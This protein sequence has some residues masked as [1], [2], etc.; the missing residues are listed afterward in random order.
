M[1]LKASKSI[2]PHAAASSRVPGRN[3]RFIGR[4]SSIVRSSGFPAGVGPRRRLIHSRSF[5]V[6]ALC[7]AE[8]NSVKK[9]NLK[10][11]NPPIAIGLTS[12]TSGGSS[13][14]SSS[15]TR[16]GCCG[17]VGG[18]GEGGLVIVARDEVAQVLD[19]LGDQASSISK[20]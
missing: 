19:E 20:S 14:L 3:L 17:I 16:P 12:L 13:S 15:I 1:A 18:N 4:T 6:S 2:T 5:L 10:Q 7:T 8:T 11:V 9:R